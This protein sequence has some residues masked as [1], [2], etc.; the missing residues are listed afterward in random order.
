MSVTDSGGADPDHRRRAP[1]T[2]VIADA[3]LTAGAAVLQTGNTGVPCS[4]ASG[5][6]SFTDAN[7]GATDRRLHRH[8]RLGRRLAQQRRH[9]RQRRRPGS[10]NVSGSHTYAKPGVYTVTT[11]VVDDGGST[12]T[13]I[14]SFTVT[15]LPVTGATKSFT[16]VEGQ[17]TGPFV[18]ATF[19]DPNTLATVADVNATLAVGGWGDGTPAV[20]GRR[21]HRPADRRRSGQ[22]RADLRRPR[23]PHLRRGDASGPARH[24]QRHHHDLR[25][26]TTTL[27]SPPGGGVTVL[28]ARLTGSSGNAI[29]GVEGSSTGTVLLGTFVDANQAATVADFTTGGGLVVVDWGDG[30]APLPLDAGNLTAIGTPDGVTWIISAAHTYTEEGTY[31]Y[32]ITVTDDGGCVHHR[33]RLGH[34]RRRRAHRRPA[35]A[36]R[37]QHR[38]RAA[39]HHGRRHLHR[40]QHRSPPRRLHRHHRLGRRLADQPPAPSSPPPPPASST[41][42]A[43]TPTPSP[44]S[45]P[46]RSPS[47]TTAAPGTSSP[48]RPITVTDLPVTGAV[49]QLHRR[50]GPEHRHDRAGDLRG[51]QHA[52]HRR[53]RARDPARRRLG[54]R[55]ADARSSRSPSSQIGVDATNGDPIFEVLGSHTYAEEGTFTVNINVT[56]LAA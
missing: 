4:P 22:R 18:L 23:Q 31:S 34:R 2:A 8:D 1:R 46:S 33:R 12:T 30:S 53:R 38:R 25:R 41:S 9:L 13:L 10:F 24:A 49:Q 17:N 36:A 42:R 47:P 3:P 55:H 45:T 19:E 48:A 6:G 43:A 11:N 51:S 27:T 44:A 56:T 40:R 5:V 52:G 35:T 15:D 29:T 37:A 32:T 14:A 50:R 16:A 21:A 54:R 28:D 20:A 7:P 26:R 39:R